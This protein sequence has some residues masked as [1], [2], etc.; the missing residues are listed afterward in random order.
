[1]L[2]IWKDLSSSIRAGSFESVRKEGSGLEPYF[3]RVCVGVAE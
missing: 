2:D 3:L 1:M